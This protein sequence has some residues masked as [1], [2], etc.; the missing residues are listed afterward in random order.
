MSME[1]LI[2]A[3]G[4]L[5]DAPLGVDAEV[6]LSLAGVQEKLVLTRMPD[7]A[8]G[9]PVDGTPSTHILKPD[10]AA[11]PNSVENEAFCMRFARELGLLTA[12]IETTSLGSRKVLIVERYDRI[13]GADGKVTRVHQEDLCQALGVHPRNKYESEGGPSL[14][15]VARVLTASNDRNVLEELLRAVTFNVIVGNA[16][17]HAKNLS[18][19]HDEG[20]AITFAPLYDLISTMLYP[21]LTKKMAMYIDNVRRIDSVSLDRIV[22]EAASWGMARARALDVARGVIDNVPAAAG[23]AQRATSGVP[24]ELRAIVDRQCARLLA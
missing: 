9:R 5:K 16:D 11:Y 18:V 24:D 20:G 13:V 12:S 3:V 22:N 23:A 14:R 8:W 4:R 2:A 15:Q 7:G 1:E 17:A 21:A 6:R 19:I 10:I